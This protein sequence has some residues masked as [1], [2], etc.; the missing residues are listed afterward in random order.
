MDCIDAHDF[1]QRKMQRDGDIRHGLHAGIGGGA[2]EDALQR[3][4]GHGA[5]IRKGGGGQVQCGH[6]VADQI[7]IYHVFAP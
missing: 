5:D 2:A 6:P 1:I 7:D 4:L 3:A